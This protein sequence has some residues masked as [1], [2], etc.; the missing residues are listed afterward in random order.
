M[1]G[2]RTQAQLA[3]FLA[4]LDAEHERIREALRGAWQGAALAAPA[5][6]TQ[7]VSAGALQSGDKE[8]RGPI[9]TAQQWSSEQFLALR[10]K[11]L[12]RETEDVLWRSAATV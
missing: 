10:R 2:T 8:A 7:P 12:R 6:D 4:K 1:S 5:G 9:R 11:A 3:E